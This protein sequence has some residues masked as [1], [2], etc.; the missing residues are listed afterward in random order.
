[1]ELPDKDLSPIIKLFDGIVDRVT[2]DPEEKKKIKL[3]LLNEVGSIARAAGQMAT[4]QV[5]ASS[6]SVL[7]SGWR[8]AAAWIAVFGFACQVAVYPILRC[9]IAHYGWHVT[10]PDID[11]TTMVSLLTALLGFGSMRTID[12]LNNVDTKQI[13]G[14]KEK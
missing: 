6:C 10:L 14:S 1:M 13:Y 7:V 11:M 12:K 5:E 8:P 3:E 4:N 9:I 2:T